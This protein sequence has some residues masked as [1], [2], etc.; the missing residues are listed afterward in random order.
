MI[1]KLIRVSRDL[2]NRLIHP[3]A[4]ALTYFTAI[5]NVGDLISP[6]IV[7]RLSGRPIYKAET[8]KFP[9]LRAV[10]SVIGSATCQSYIWGSGSIDGILPKQTLDINKIFALR[11]KKTL[12]MLQTRYPLDS[13]LPLGDPALLMPL[14]YTPIEEKLYS[15]GII[16]HFSDLEI[17]DEIIEQI[18]E[19]ICMLD[20]RMQPEHFISRLLRCERIIS[21]SLHGLILADAYKIPN[22]W[23]SFSNLLLG[24]TWKFEDY[25][26]MTTNEKPRALIIKSKSDFHNL[27]SSIR[28]I[29]MINEYIGSPEKLEKS[30]PSKL[31]KRADSNLLCK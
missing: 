3:E 4:L 15:V 17:V 28:K 19:D 10:G 2:H 14:M 30:F 9:H 23:V 25:Y 18:G 31:C 13:D 12:E 20:V 5:P 11:G 24:G 6:Y 21:S 29:A 1:S 7:T 22:V 16:P 8:A 27:L 26:S